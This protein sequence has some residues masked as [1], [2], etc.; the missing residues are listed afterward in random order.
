[1]SID[2]KR[3][4]ELLRHLSST[5]PQVSGVIFKG[6]KDAALNLGALALEWCEAKA[7]LEGLNGP[8]VQAYMVFMEKWRAYLS[9]ALDGGKP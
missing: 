2:P 6:E 8:H 7:V 5:G 1:M 4:V 9:A 3:A